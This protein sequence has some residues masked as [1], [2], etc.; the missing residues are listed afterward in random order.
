MFDHPWG[1]TSPLYGAVPYQAS[2]I[3]IEQDYCNNSLYFFLAN[4]DSMIDQKNGLIMYN[5]PVIEVDIGKYL[6]LFQN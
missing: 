4:S 3:V 6:N 5:C 2:T 1:N